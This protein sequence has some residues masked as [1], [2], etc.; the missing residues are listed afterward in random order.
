MRRLE[1][2][3]KDVRAV[4]FTPAGRL[5]SGGSDRTVRI[6]DPLSGECRHVIQ[7]RRVV[8]ALAVSPDGSTLA[9]AGRARGR[10][11]INTVPLWD[12]SKAQDM[13]ECIWWME[14]QTYAIW[15]LAY[16]A[17]GRY[18][19]AACRRPG[20]ANVLDGG[21]GRWWGRGGPPEMG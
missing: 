17:D 1:G 14:P 3:T 15:S 7:A 5:V 2:H 20:S 16:S 6:W 4:V 12:L 18:L 19:A 13:G 10:E 8:Y 21:G 9:Y 11:G